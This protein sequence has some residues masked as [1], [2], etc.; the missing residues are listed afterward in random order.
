MVKQFPEIFNVDFT[1]GMELELDK[2]EEGELGWRAV[3]KDFWGPFDKSLKNVQFGALIAEA[4]D[5][6][7]HRDGALPRLRRQAR[8]ARRIL[9][10]VP[11]LRESPEALQVHAAA[12]GREGE[13]ED[14]GHP[15]SSLRP[16]DGRPSGTQRRVPRLQHLPEVPRHALHADGR[17]L[18][19]GRR[20]AGRAP[21]EE[22]RHG[23][24]RLLQR[25]LR[26]RRLEQAGGGDLSGVRLRRWIP[27]PAS[28][29]A[30]AGSST[31]APLVPDP[32]SS[33]APPA[34]GEASVRPGPGR[35]A[36]LV[37]HLPYK[38]GVAGS[39]PA[40]PMGKRPAQA[41][42]FFGRDGRGGERLGRL[43]K[44]ILESCRDAGARHSFRATPGDT[45][46][47]MATPT[48][49]SERLSLTVGCA[50]AA[51]MLGVHPATL[52][53]W[54]R[55][56]A[57]DDLQRDEPGLVDREDLEARRRVGHVGAA[58]EGGASP[59]PEVPSPRCCSWCT[60]RRARR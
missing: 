37:E 7:A 53:R 26:L 14:D 29:P 60:P 8:A 13:A 31:T 21:L 45:R 47:R 48:K 4:H 9:R 40:P 59:R 25:G 20:R 19:E 22:A 57:V 42:F 6:S 15:L 33:L 58:F 56:G 3:L 12:Q 10:A 2:V 41:G 28:R 32:A 43:C 18:P 30:C 5:L 46:K 1:S 39:S 50:E 44:A 11:R 16:A 49:T 55:L 52:R 54:V 51:D 24:L 17:L 23:V 34:V 38:Q 27:R 36:Q 35:L